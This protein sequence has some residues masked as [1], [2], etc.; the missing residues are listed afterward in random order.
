MPAKKPKRAVADNGREI[1]YPQYRS[2]DR[3]YQY[4]NALGAAEGRE[5]LGVSYA[6]PHDPEG[7]PPILFQDREGRYV[8]AANNLN[9][10]PFSM[11][12]AETYARAMLTRQW[13]LN[14]ETMV[15]GRTGLTLN[16]QHRLVGLYL[17][18][19][20]R[21]GP[22]A[23]AWAAYWGEQEVAIECTLV[24]G[25]EESTQVISTMDTARPRNFRDVVFTTPQL[26]DL[27]PKQRKQ[28]SS[29]LH[30]AVKKLWARTGVED[31]A[32]W[33]RMTNPVAMQW[34]GRHGRLVDCVKKM[35]DLWQHGRL[36][37][38]LSPGYSAALLYLMAASATDPD[39]YRAGRSEQ[40]IDWQHWDQANTFWERLAHGEEPL[41]KI[42]TLARR[43]GSQGDIEGYIFSD[44]EGGGS[45]K[46]RIGVL[47][48]AWQLFVAGTTK[49]KAKDLHLEYDTQ[50][51]YY[52]LLQPPC[53]GGIDL[54]DDPDVAALALAPEDDSEDETDGSVPEVDVAQGMAA[55]LS[56]RIRAGQK[57]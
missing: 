40:E 15:I 22:Q 20:D 46:E 38:Y 33:G 17:A 3:L 27:P 52:R 36:E 43:P 7:S 12:L 25:V 13:E 9:N 53:A 4:G 51:G 55:S 48:Q 34:L 41:D 10:R 5:L 39:G 50:D 35:I 42:R 19:Q 11:A 8:R 31:D 47:C 44:G 26:A 57:P 21:T 14:G 16:A 24:T 49:I 29:V 56:A 30:H 1:I 23:E 2:V 6:T 45:L 28:A 37:H 32:F 54:G 18:E